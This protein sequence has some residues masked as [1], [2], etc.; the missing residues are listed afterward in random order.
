MVIQAMISVM[1]IVGY[2]M[3]R[4]KVDGVGADPKNEVLRDEAQ[5]FGW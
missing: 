4:L 5:K 2:T 1:E 3:G